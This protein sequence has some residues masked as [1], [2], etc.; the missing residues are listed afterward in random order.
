MSAGWLTVL[1]AVLGYGLGSINSALLVCRLLGL[2]DIRR[3]GS[4]N[5]GM[6]NMLRI[7]GK[8]A[9]ALTASGDLLKA[10]AAVLAARA[11]MLAAG[12]A[13][14]FDPGYLCGLFVLIGHIW[15][16]F[17]AFRGGKGVIGAGRHP[18]GRPDRF[19]AFWLCAAVIV[20]WIRHT[21]SLVSIT[22]AIL[23]TPLTLAIDLV[24]GVNPFWD[25][26]FALLFALLVIVSHRENIRR[27]QTHKE[28]PLWPDE[29]RE[30]GNLKWV[31]ICAG[32][33]ERSS[34]SGPCSFP[35]RP[36][37]VF[38]LQH[39]DTGD[40]QQEQRDHQRADHQPERCP[41]LAAIRKIPHQS[42]DSPK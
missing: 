18:A 15:P 22:A 16:V 2:D 28:G 34:W 36:S 26:L 35:V 24:E 9:G 4:G 7:Y 29:K 32:A 40:E 12:S 3:H 21:I 11:V 5:A 17:F 13:L 8:K 41:W 31:L 42:R 23:V 39:R 10:I 33:A 19:R 20:F 27:L 30:D 38:F 14:P 25:T 6:T 37:G 1:L